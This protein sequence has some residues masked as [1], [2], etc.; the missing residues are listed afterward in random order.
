MKIKA[1]DLLIKYLEQEGVEYVF[2]VPGGVLEPINNALYESKKIT[3]ILAKHEE[4][5]A[6]M[7]CGYAQV[8]GKLGV[9]MGT[10]G[11]GCTNLMTGVASAYGDSTPVL[12]LTGQV[13][14]S[15]FGKGALQES[16][17]EGIDAVAMFKPL[18]KYS[19]MVFKASMVPEMIRRALRHAF[20]GRP[21]PVHLNLPRDVMGGEIDL[22]LRKAETY[23]G[24]CQ[25]FDRES[26][27]RASAYLLKAERPAMLLGN[28]TLLSDAA[29]EAKAIAEMLNIPVATTPKAK[30]VFPSDHPLS[31][32]P[33]G[34]AS[35]LLAEKYLTGGVDVF[36]TVGTRFT[37]WS[38]QA[39]DKRLLPTKALLQIDIDPYEIG[40]NYPVTVGLVG[41]AKAILTE[42][43]YEMKRQIKEVADFKPNLSM[44]EFNKFK[45][46]SPIYLDE[47]KMYSNS[48][49]IKPQRL[50]KDLRE[51]L[52]RNTIVFVDAGNS[53]T[54]G[55]HYFPVYLPRTYI[56]GIGF[57]SMGYATAA[58]VGGKFAA[59]DKPV[60]AIVG[61]G[62]FL[63]NGMEIATAVNYNLPVIWV[64]LNDAQL[65]MVYHGQK[66]A[67]NAH[68]VVSTFKKVDFCKVAEGL[69]ARGIRIEKPGE[70]NPELMDEI[71][72][73]GRPTV[74]DVAI[75]PE[76]PPPM[77]YRVAALEEIYD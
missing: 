19:A 18:T 28:G 48:N 46:E 14:T 39:W 43:Y 66:M 65:G 68:V 42:I 36:L 61:D 7:A 50:M 32:G 67:S 29:E 41:D 3:P 60:V 21:G 71:L 25:P 47:E 76:E 64:I 31:I 70:I 27:K 72:S 23:R 11:P 2:E 15:T 69:G 5:A 10:T 73:S 30:S 20:S 63:M 77:K 9:C 33:F 37:E 45:G 24:C 74:L 59:P 17:S 22:D 62:A 1:A 34:L 49:P 58:A 26:I 6:F 38:T 44:A 4:G 53:Y 51:S 12:V 54:W 35:S 55:I 16:S 40:K 8:S 56:M 13:S 57:A 52:P 75:D